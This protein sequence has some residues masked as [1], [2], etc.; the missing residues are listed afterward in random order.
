MLKQRDRAVIALV[1]ALFVAP[2][3]GQQPVQNPPPKLPAQQ[4][5]PPPSLQQKPPSVDSD[6]V[7]RINTNLVQIDTVVTKNDKQVTDLTAAD[8]EVFEDG[9]PQQIT[10]FSYVWT[11]PKTPNTVVAK[12]VS[13]V[14]KGINTPPVVPPLI[15]ADEPHR[16][17]ALVVDD[18]GISMESMGEIRGQLRKFV[19]EQVEPNDL[20][21]I[22]RTGG[23]VGALQQFTNDKR[24]LLRAVDSVKWN[25]CS[26]A[27]ISIFPPATATTADSGG[28]EIVRQGNN[29]VGLCSDPSRPLGGSIGALRFI[30]QG[31]RDLPG[32]KS[33]VIFS[34]SL[35]T[36]YPASS[37]PSSVPTR[38]SSEPRDNSPLSNYGDLQRLAELAI[39]SSVVIYGVD[40]RGLQPLGP[41]AA[42]TFGAN[43]SPVGDQPFRTLSTRAH[44]LTDN[45]TG[46]DLLAR[47]TGGFLVKNSNSFGLKRIAQDQS[48]YYL[49]GYRPTDFTF[50]RRFH[51]IT[52]KVS[53]PGLSVRTRSGF[54]GMTDEEA[55][56][57]QL[58]NHDRVNL[59]L[60]S[61]FA[62]SDIEVHLTALFA[63]VP[64]AGSMVRSLIYF[65]GHDLVFT[66]EPGDWHKATVNLAAA[67]F[68]DNGSI[69]QHLIQ[70]RA[71]RVHRPEYER[72]RRD[73]L[74]YQIDVPVSKPGAYQF[75]VAI[76]DEGSSLMGTARQ[77][78]DVPETK[79]HALLLS[80]ITV[81]GDAANPKGSEGVRSAISM[82]SPAI[83]R[84]APAEDLWFGYM[85]YN[86]K[87][88]KTSV[89][90][91]L[92]AQARLFHDGKL[93][94]SGIPKQIE[95]NGQADLKRISS[96]GGIKLGPALEPGEYL[97]QIVVTEMLAKDK[98]RIATQWID[99]DI[100]K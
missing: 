74:V 78:I 77:F 2:V 80:G 54:F 59:A 98:S 60:M 57:L 29:G 22:I 65:P 16:T 94:Y 6:D 39:R 50:N 70:T 91:S 43:L 67:V 85:I 12:T 44:I 42:D 18:L 35:P 45:R 72:L 90:S 34:E 14:G 76:R 25:H 52:V 73:G 1:L 40:T 96:G 69:V 5:P 24:L 27:G 38:A 63:D 68:G 9:K 8:F 23:E 87:A 75:R 97:L 15:R 95:T 92:T 51:H 36:D 89:P 48:G 49:I 66:D 33:M 61:P 84:F 86:A 58:T 100:V 62:T 81:S 41:T 28:D 26:R 10:N 20:I 71:I 30:L 7:V 46:Q 32:R 93:V 99:F 21:A 11:V 88:E 4:P 83:R 13:P 19:N 3:R 55:R 64:N 37:L 82:S 53:T 79:K 31:M 47:E 56:P 17:I